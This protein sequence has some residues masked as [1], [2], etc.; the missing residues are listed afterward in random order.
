M[1]TSP[2]NQ[3]QGKATRSFVRPPFTSVAIGC[4][5]LFATLQLHAGTVAYWR[6]EGDGI[7]VPPVG[8]QVEDSNGR[9]TTT[10][11]VGVRMVD[12]SGNGNTIWSWDYPAAGHTYATDVPSA[13]VAQTGAANTFSA[14]SSGAS[15]TIFT[16]SAQSHPSGT[17]IETIT[18]LAWTIEASIKNTSGVGNWR[19]FVGRDGNTVTTGEAGRAPPLGRIEGEVLWIEF[20]KGL[21][22]LDIGA[23]GGKPRQD[24]SVG[25]RQEAGTMAQAERLAERVSSFEL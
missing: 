25:E 5:M 16:W 22:G 1:N 24:S 7:N 17:D 23:R 14:A 4:L 8:S 11:G 10:T 19:T 2:R 18:P 15:P 3:L 20:G 12:V 13:T 6:F 21:A 9:T